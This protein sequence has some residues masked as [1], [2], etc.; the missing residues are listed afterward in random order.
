MS[1]DVNILLTLDLQFTITDANENFHKR[2]KVNPYFIISN[3]ISNTI[4]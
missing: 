3:Q 2:R 1:K 4:R